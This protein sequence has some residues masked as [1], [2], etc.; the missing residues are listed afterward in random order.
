MLVLLWS[1]AL[2]ACSGAD[3][4]TESAGSSPAIEAPEPAVVPAAPEW[5]EV[6]AE[7]V[8]ARLRAH[9][10]PFLLVNVWST[11]CEPCVEEMPMLVRVAREHEARGLGLVLLSADPRSQR[12]AAR[13]LLREHGAPLP[14]W[15]KTG[16]DDAFVRALHPAWSGALPATLLLDRE[17]RVVR[18]FP[19]Q[20]GEDELR[21]AIGELV[22]G[23]A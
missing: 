16:S 19:E 1:G 2:A 11:W 8:G 14:G 12:E 3:E 6:D 18:F 23:D 20:V 13:A 10:A 4:Q 21:A 15:I 7:S 9:P 17:R 5:I 22:G